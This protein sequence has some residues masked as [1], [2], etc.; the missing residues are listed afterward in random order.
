MVGIVACTVLFQDDFGTPRIAPFAGG[1]K[2]AISLEFDDSM[3]SQVENALPL[4]KARGIRATFF[5]NPGV[6]HYAPLKGTFEVDI[7][8]AG[9]EVGN[10][11]WTHSGARNVAEMDEQ[12]R[13]CAEVLTRIY[14]KRPRLMSFATPGGVPWD[15]PEADQQAVLKRYRLIRA[16]D[17]HFFE[18]EK[19]N[20]I[21]FV[22][23]ARR[24]G[25][26][27]RIGFHGIGGEWL[28]TSVPTLGR[29]LDHLHRHRTTVWTAP[30]IE[31]Y[32]YVRERDAARPLRLT[33]VSARGF[34][35]RVD[36]DPK[37]L[38]TYG[39]PVAALWDQPL[40]VEVPVPPS[41]RTFEVRQGGRTARGRTEMMGGRRW[42]RFDV[43]PNVGAARISG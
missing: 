26:W 2:A 14:G 36:C 3:R 19:T 42:A 27:K 22:D 24:E 16:D 32:K 39:L 11:T 28:S 34:S 41:W 5:I 1:T 23:A 10:H 13:R 33:D 30:S 8:K 4:L 18:E 12:V 25:S 29:L 37:R 40:T 20:P 9:H 31:I 35:L 15:V 38:D 6:T 17:R 43:R 7:P 21:T